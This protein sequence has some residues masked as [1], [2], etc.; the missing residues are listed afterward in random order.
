MINVIFQENDTRS[1]EKWSQAERSKKP[2]FSGFKFI[3]SSYPRTAD[4]T[5]VLQ[6]EGTLD[7]REEKRHDLLPGHIFSLPTGT[8]VLDFYTD[9]TFKDT[10][11][12]D[13]EQVVNSLT[14][15]NP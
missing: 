3:S 6:V 11:L 5:R 4:G 10:V 1:L 2:P 14:L 13:F 8:V 12:P 15:L 9:D 7:R